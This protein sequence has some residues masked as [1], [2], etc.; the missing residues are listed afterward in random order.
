MTPTLGRHREGSLSGSSGMCQESATNCAVS[1]TTP[2]RRAPTRRV[3]AAPRHARARPADGRTPE[4]AC[5]S[6]RRTRSGRG[7][8]T[9]WPTVAGVAASNVRRAA[10]GRGAED[11]RPDRSAANDATQDDDVGGLDGVRGLHEIGQHERASVGDPHRGRELPRCLLVPVHH[12]DD[13]AALGAPAYAAR[14]GSGRSRRRPPSP[15]RHRGRPLPPTSA[16]CIASVPPRPLRRYRRSARRAALLAED[17]ERLTGA[18]RARHDGQHASPAPGVRP[19]GNEAVATAT[20]RRRRRGSSAAANS[21]GCAPRGR[22]RARRAP[23]RA[24]SGR[25]RPGRTRAR[26]AAPRRSGEGRGP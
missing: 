4:T 25:A 17:V 12:L 16:I 3:R 23:G 24:R 7:R 9:C 1:Q 5:A 13:A 26:S 15:S 8:T 19:H 14:P 11:R 21:A 10:T 18:A 6:A 20:A 2:R 22:R